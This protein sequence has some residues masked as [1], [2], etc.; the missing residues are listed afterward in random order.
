M[1]ETF[2]KAGYTILDSKFSISQLK[3]KLTNYE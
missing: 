1:P 2:K 3:N